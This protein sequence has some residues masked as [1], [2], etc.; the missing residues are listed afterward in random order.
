MGAA[1]VE[2][3]RSPVV[4]ERIGKDD[5][6]IVRLHLGQHFHIQYSGEFGAR[7]TPPVVGK[8]Y[9][10]LRASRVECFSVF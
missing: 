8:R 3:A 6:V 1:R 9:S 5:I 7:N 10:T 2:E 4:S